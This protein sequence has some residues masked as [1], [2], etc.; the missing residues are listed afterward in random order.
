MHPA[1]LVY[2]PDVQHR[3]VSVGKTFE[4]IEETSRA[5]IGHFADPAFA[6]ISF[7]TIYVG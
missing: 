7:P 4:D 5:V 6:L 1:R 2:S 3:L